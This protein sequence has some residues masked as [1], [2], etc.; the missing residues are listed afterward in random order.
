MGRNQLKLAALA[1]FRILARPIVGLMLRAGVTFK[2]LSEVLRLVCVSVASEEYGKHGRPANI[3]RVA[4]LTDMSRRDVRRAREMLK[5]ES[6][7]ALATLNHMSRATR[8]LS[9]W[10]QDADYRSQS[11]KPRLLKMDGEGG[12]AS[13]VRRHAPDIPPTAMLKELKRIGAVHE[14]KTG[15]LRP[16]SRTFIPTPLD[17]ESVI[18]AGEVIGDLARTISH[19]LNDNNGARFE[20]RATS[21]VIPRSLSRSFNRYL[22][23][24][25]M[26][27]LEDVDSWLT[28]HETDDSTKR[29]VRLGVGVYLIMED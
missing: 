14:T 16:V 9:G 11:G 2:E 15:L 7:E 12:F 6:D 24:R 5:L 1:S 4:I 28:E 19:N 3:S 27:F 21:R 26:E 13:L 23:D 17:P 29:Q 8:I 22:D 18:R 25:G 20:R 10:F